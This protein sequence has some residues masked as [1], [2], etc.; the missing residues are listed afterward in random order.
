MHMVHWY[1]PIVTHSLSPFVVQKYFSVHIHVGSSHSM[2]KIDGTEGED[3]HVKYDVKHL[4]PI[5]FPGF[6]FQ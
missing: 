4:L 3:F 6:L 2:K 1:T 5:V